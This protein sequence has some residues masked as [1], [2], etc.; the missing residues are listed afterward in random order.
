MASRHIPNYFA[1][2]LCIFK[3][4]ICLVDGEVESF[5]DVEVEPMELGDGDYMS[6]RTGPCDGDSIVIGSFSPFINPTA[7]YRAKNTMV[8]EPAYKCVKNLGLYGR[9]RQDFETKIRKRTGDPTTVLTND[10]PMENVPFTDYFI[11]VAQEV[12]VCSESGNRGST[13]YI[14]RNELFSMKDIRE[15]HFGLG[16]SVSVMKHHLTFGKRVKIEEIKY[17]LYDEENQALTKTSKILIKSYQIQE[18]TE[19]ISIPNQSNK[20]DRST[21]NSENPAM[22]H[23]EV[24]S[25]GESYKI[26]SSWKKI[27]DHSQP[28]NIEI[29][30]KKIPYLNPASFRPEVYKVHDRLSEETE[31]HHKIFA[32]ISD[33]KF[34]KLFT[35]VQRSIWRCV[36]YAKA[37]KTKDPHI[38]RDPAFYRVVHEV[39][40]KKSIKDVLFFPRD[41]HYVYAVKL[42]NGE[43]TLRYKDVSYYYCHNWKRMDK[44]DVQI[45]LHREESEFVGIEYEGRKDKRNVKEVYYHL[46]IENVFSTFIHDY[47]Y[48]LRVGT[49]TTTTVVEKRNAECKKI[50]YGKMEDIFQ[51]HVTILMNK[52]GVL[53]SQ[54]TIHGDYRQIFFKYTKQ[55]AFL[56]TSAATSI[57]RVVNELSFKMPVSEI[58]TFDGV[59]ISTQRTLDKDYSKLFVDIT[60]VK[61]ID[62]STKRAVKYVGQLIFQEYVPLY[63]NSIK[64]TKK[65][66]FTTEDEIIRLID[67]PKTREEFRESYWSPNLSNSLVTFGGGI[68]TLTFHNNVKVKSKDLET[69][70]FC[71]LSKNRSQIK[72]LA[73][74]SISDRDGKELAAMANQTDSETNSK[75]FEGL[76]TE[77]WTCNLK[78]QQEEKTDEEGKTQNE[79]GMGKEGKTENKV[80]NGELIR[81]VNKQKIKESAPGSVGMISYGAM[82]EVWIAA[83]KGDEFTTNAKNVRYYTENEN[84]ELNLVELKGYRVLEKKSKKLSE[85]WMS[86]KRELIN[87]FDR[88]KRTKPTRIYKSL[89]PTLRMYKKIFDPAGKLNLVIG[90]HWKKVFGKKY[91]L[92]LCNRTTT[93]GTIINKYKPE[94]RTDG[95]LAQ[96]VDSYIDKLS[97]EVWECRDEDDSTERIRRVVNRFKIDYNR[98]VEISLKNLYF[99]DG[100]AVSYGNY[101]DR[102]SFI[103]T[104]EIGEVKYLSLNDDTVLKYE[105]MTKLEGSNGFQYATHLP[106]TE[107]CIFQEPG[108]TPLNR[109]STQ[110]TWLLKREYVPRIF[111]YR[112][113]TEQ[114]IFKRTEVPL[115]SFVDWFIPFTKTEETGMVYNRNGEQLTWICQ[116]L[117]GVKY[118]KVLTRLVFLSTIDVAAVYHYNGVIINTFPSPHEEGKTAIEIMEIKYYKHDVSGNSTK[119][120]KFDGFVS[121]VERSQP[122][123][124]SSY[125]TGHEVRYYLDTPILHFKEGL[126][127]ERGVAIEL[128]SQPE[129]TFDNLGRDEVICKEIADHQLKNI[130]ATKMFTNFLD[131]PAPQ[132]EPANSQTS[133]TSL[134]TT[135]TV[136]ATSVR[137]M[138]WAAIKEDFDSH[139]YKRSQKLW[140]C[141]RDTKHIFHAVMNVMVLTAELHVARAF[142]REGVK[143]DIV[144]LPDKQKVIETTE[145]KFFTVDEQSDIKIVSYAPQRCQNDFYN[146]EI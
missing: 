49:P 78:Q 29:R 53:H 92:I 85:T 144:T 142:H 74:F 95:L 120:V 11:Y 139:F 33:E 51:T 115:E 17:F 116:S 141:T 28:T 69:V 98:I 108:E 57:Y 146:V 101:S 136:P 145:L 41:I 113:D 86:G 76:E 71:K 14:V 88:P 40:G 10:G 48:N 84:K 50:D 125:Y 103:S 39:I 99:F 54:E 111:Y 137:Q 55:E 2:W 61:Y 8:Y 82:D 37:T 18:D 26:G 117:E 66:V 27:A 25:L 59:G 42:I 32:K 119:L 104:L 21:I 91:M 97:Q 58:Q 83:D 75:Y 132:A 44:S 133:S 130:Y 16:V 47:G 45:N 46:G 63:D 79:R 64:T 67:L 80:S 81:V 12:W 135:T 128:G 73:I 127:V 5:I 62:S 106:N 1:L 24:S 4:S 36:H 13:F 52:N 121:Y 138:Q 124:R 22:E 109:D 87:D 129:E 34:E 96:S 114:N 43:N 134:P 110:E 35:I 90:S 15:V 7:D 72:P 9:H 107:L 140:N 56:C 123:E 94:L 31:Y 60:E 30:C 6:K 23:F 3:F 126:H 20:F 65:R 122:G 70:F 118:T 68:N 19:Q 105:G 131:A 89:Q 112:E 77:I 38:T 100:I 93:K 102:G 143:V